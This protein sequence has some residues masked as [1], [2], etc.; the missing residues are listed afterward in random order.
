MVYK[1][2]YKVLGEKYRIKI[3]DL[4][5]MNLMGLCDRQKKVIYM[6][7][8]L[9]TDQYDF[10]TTLLHELGH[11]VAFESSLFQGGLSHEIEEI[12]TDQNSK[13]FYTEVLKP[14]IDLIPEDYMSES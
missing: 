14:L 4:S 8:T 7:K 9:L 12:W 1:K 10:Y 11:A 6:D 3:T 2:V 13:V 5:S